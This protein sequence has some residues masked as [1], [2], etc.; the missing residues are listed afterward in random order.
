MGHYSDGHIFPYGDIHPGEE[1]FIILK[2]IMETIRH[3]VIH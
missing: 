2:S 1:G 3:G